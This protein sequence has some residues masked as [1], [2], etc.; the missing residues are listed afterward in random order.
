MDVNVEPLS[1]LLHLL[2]PRSTMSA[3]FDMGGDWSLSF[4]GVHKQIKCYVILSGQCW[5]TV[6]GVE[7]AV[8]LHGGDCFVMPNGRRFVMASDLA[9]P[10]VPAS[11]VFA[12]ARAGEIMT[13]G[14]GGN[15]SLVGTRFSVSGQHAEMLL[16]LLPPVVHLTGE[17]EQVSLRWSVKRM[18]E[19][20]KEE[21]PGGSL[22]A[23]D[24]AHVILVQALR[25]H[26][27]ET[28]DHGTG[29]FFALADKQLGSAITAMHADPAR[30]WT[31]KELG[32]EAGQSRSVFASRFKEVV[33][34][35][36]MQYLV[37]WRMLLACEKLER[38]DMHV[39]AIA[40]AL[41]YESEGAFSTAFKRVIGC[42]PRRYGRQSEIRTQVQ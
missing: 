20:F 11:T 21:R 29:W 1:E 38:T 37:R 40:D 9:L 34:E 30:R 36:P 32:E 24:L 5:L 17:S 28:L 27:A 35:A 16:G 39:A 15:F 25:L 4:G 19:E 23:D 42:S 26:G 22:I 41:G 7:G 33:G 18:M 10:A 2:R 8:V 13:V 31:L 14:G 12:D 3:G 6:E